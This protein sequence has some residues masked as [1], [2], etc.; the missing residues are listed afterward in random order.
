[1]DTVGKI[2]LQE[3]FKTIK[4]FCEETHGSTN[5]DKDVVFVQGDSSELFAPFKYLQKKE[6]LLK[7][8]NTLLRQG[9]IYD[10][11][12]FLPNIKFKAWYE[13]QFSRKLTKRIEKKILILHVPENKTIFDC[14]SAVNKNYE[15]LRKNLVLLN[16]KKFP[17][18]LGE[19]YAKCVFGLKQVK[20]T[21]QRGF[22]F[23]LGDKRAEVIVHSGDISSPKGVKIK[24]SLIQLSDFCVVIYIANNFM[25]RE[26]CLLDSDFVMR[27]FA[28]KGH[29]IFLKD[30]DIKTYFFSKS[31]KSQDKV[32]N[33]SALLKFCSP[34]LAMKIAERF[35]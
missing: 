4:V 20:S 35:Q 30:S 8:D 34:T 18:Q 21:S 25:I 5:Y 1:M 29:T 24:K 19:W 32:I 13:K 15:E 3:L 11:V 17:V 26:I 23:L 2:D 9:M 10:S 33:A 27:K 22:D 12:D 14:I 16:S 6:P 7:N 31:D 28:G